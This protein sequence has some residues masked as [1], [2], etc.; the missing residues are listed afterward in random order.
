MFSKQLTNKERFNEVVSDAIETVA[1]SNLSDKETALWI[2]GVER[3]VEMIELRG[4]FMDYDLDKKELLVR[5]SD[6]LEIYIANGKCNCRAGQQG[7]G[8]CQHR[9]AA[10][11][12]KRY[13]E[14]GEETRPT[15]QEMDS[16]IY[17][18]SQP[19][20]EKIG[21]MRI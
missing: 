15:N 13:F 6:L 2:K 17:C 8:R 21:A 14:R 19:K 1:Q 10:K 3:A 12:F 18:K 7:N 4:E 16:A 11:L 20:S 5:S 9:L